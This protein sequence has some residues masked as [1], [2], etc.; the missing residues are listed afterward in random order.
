M[1]IINNTPRSRAEPGNEISVL[2]RQFAEGGGVGVGEFQMGGAGNNN[3]TVHLAFELPDG[4]D[5]SKRGLLV[6]SIFECNG[7]RR[8]PLFDVLGAGDGRAGQFPER[9]VD[10]DLLEFTGIL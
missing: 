6:Q 7:C 10:F 4:T 1:W 5:E 2:I 3:L 8:V 9:R